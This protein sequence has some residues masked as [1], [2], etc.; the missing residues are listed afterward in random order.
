MMILDMTVDD[1]SIDDG[2]DLPKSSVIVVVVTVMAFLRTGNNKFSRK[3]RLKSLGKSGTKNK[4]YWLTF[5]YN[6]AI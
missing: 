6:K 4:L 5:P 2:I 1:D 3:I